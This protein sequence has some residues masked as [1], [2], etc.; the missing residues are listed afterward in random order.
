[1]YK[2]LIT[3]L[4][5][6]FCSLNECFS[7]ILITKKIFHSVQKKLYFCSVYVNIDDYEGQD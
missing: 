1:M 4:R 6:V 5:I 2:K 7:Y 3:F